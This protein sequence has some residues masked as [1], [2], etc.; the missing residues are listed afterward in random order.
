MLVPTRGRPELLQR[1]I[2]SLYHQSH[3]PE[4]IEVILYI[5][6][7]DYETLELQFETP[8]VKRVVGKRNTMGK[9]NWECFSA[10]TGDIIFLCNDDVVVQ[11]RNWDDC[12]REHVAKM[13]DWV[14]LMYPND[15]Y[16]KGDLCTFPVLSRKY[17]ET[18]SEPFPL[19]YKGAFIDYHLM[20]IFNRLKGYGL[21]KINY[22]DNVVFEHMHFRAGKSKPDKTYL[23][24]SRFG[25]DET[26]VKLGLE[27]HKDVE[28]ICHAL[29][30][31]SG[32]QCM[33]LKPVNEH[34]YKSV[35]GAVLYEFTGGSSADFRWRFRIFSFLIL[36]K[37]YHKL[38]GKN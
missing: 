20:D 38:T 22:M 16:K 35:S 28:K 2:H 30:M 14:Y 37:L 29:A 31:E 36:R 34:R 24:R 12:V 8:N 13:D 3:Y 21:N 1:M 17:C 6:D 5:D 19:S 7:D 25:D 11:T 9:L 10:S 15:L 33:P 26:F 23:E 4:T 27:R 18:V 32:K